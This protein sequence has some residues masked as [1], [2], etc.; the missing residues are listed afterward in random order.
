MVSW[1]GGRGGGKERETDRQK[2]ASQSGDVMCF[3]RGRD[4]SGPAHVSPYGPGL[5]ARQQ[6][7]V[8]PVSLVPMYLLTHM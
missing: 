2:T 3:V 1:E 4:V 5:R 7:V 8:W 6:N